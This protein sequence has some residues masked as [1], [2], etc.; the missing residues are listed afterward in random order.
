[1]KIYFKMN[2][3][4]RIYIAGLSFLKLPHIMFM[5]TYEIIPKRIPFEIEYVSGIAIR[6]MNAGIDSEK[7][8]NGIFFTGSIMR[9]PTMIS[10]G[11]V[12]AEGIERKRGEKRSATAKQI[13]TTSAVSP[14][15]PP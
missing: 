15:R 4:A 14:E 1:M 11:A 2:S 13:A 6:Q 7:S 5:I 12:A 8:E 9:R 3:T 10:A